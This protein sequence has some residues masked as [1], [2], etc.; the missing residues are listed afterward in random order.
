M[1]ITLCIVI[2]ETLPFFAVRFSFKSS[3][4]V[5]IQDTFVKL[6]IL[7]HLQ[8]LNTLSNARKLEHPAPKGG[9]LVIL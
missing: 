6:T 7:N 3:F 5:T 9:A 1:L 8:M 4:S 2:T